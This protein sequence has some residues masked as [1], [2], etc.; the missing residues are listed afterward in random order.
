[1]FG[2]AVLLWRGYR[3]A[4][5]AFLY[6][7]KNWRCFRI[8]KQGHQINEEIRDKE[9]PL[10]S[11]SG[12]RLGEVEQLLVCGQEL[13]DT[14]REHEEM[15]NWAHDFYMEERAHGDISDEDLALLEE[16]VNL[17][18]LILDY[19]QISDLSPLAQLPLEY[20]SL[21][22]NEVSDLSPLSGMTEL[23]VLDL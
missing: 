15:V 11:D 21:T 6:A 2:V 17:K 5:T 18:V 10:V 7:A 8:S 23:K 16:C 1:M 20:L 4:V 14:I 12:E 13:V 3:N 9:V 22:G 19:Q